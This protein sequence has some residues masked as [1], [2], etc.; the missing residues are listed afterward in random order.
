LQAK[1]YLILLNFVKNIIQEYRKESKTYIAYSFAEIQF[2]YLGL[3]V[4]G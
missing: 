3:S 1:D 2:N 4:S